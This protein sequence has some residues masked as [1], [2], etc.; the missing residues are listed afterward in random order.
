MAR[1]FAIITGASTGIG[2]E[3]ARIAASEG[4]EL[5]IAADEPRIEAAAAGLRRNHGVPVSCV[6]AD[7]G[8]FDG[9]DRLLEAAGARRIDVL[10][11]NAGVGS[12]GAFLNQPIEKWRHSIETNVTGTVYLLQRV[13]TK[14]VAQGRGRVLVT[15]SIVGF[16]PGSFN[17]IYNATKAFIGNFTEALRD[18]LK[19]TPRVTLTTLLPGATDTEFFARAGMLST[20]VGQREKADPAQVAQ[21]GWAAMMAGK[22]HVVSGWPNKLQFLGAGL[23]PQSLLAKMHRV[24]AK[25][26]Q[27]RTQEN[28]S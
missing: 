16:I 26:H 1:K 11:A 21:D 20:R 22:G 8:T 25:P 5:L 12:G 3:I 17:A 4:Y 10:V 9:V 6:E 15:G 28:R 19:E 2:L 14:M 23:L 18:E 27:S 7:L 24:L 13:L